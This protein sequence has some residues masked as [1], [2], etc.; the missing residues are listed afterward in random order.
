M[1][2]KEIVLTP[3]QFA[4]VLNSLIL[5]ETITQIAAG[6]SVTKGELQKAMRGNKAFEAA[7]GIKTSPNALGNVTTATREAIFEALLCGHRFSDHPN[8]N[9]DRGGPKPTRRIADKTS[10]SGVSTIYTEV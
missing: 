2:A 8:G 1:K 4:K 5:G 3:E 9:S 6:L 7:Y 10:F